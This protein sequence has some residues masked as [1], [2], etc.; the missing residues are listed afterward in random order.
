MLCLLVFAGESLGVQSVVG[1]QV[2]GDVHGAAVQ[3]HQVQAG[4]I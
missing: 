4:H 1:G 3:A 2:G